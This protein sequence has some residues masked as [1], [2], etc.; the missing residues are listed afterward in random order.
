MLV[1]EPIETHTFDDPESPG[2][3]PD[4]RDPDEGGP[5][6]PSEEEQLKFHIVKVYETMDEEGQITTDAVF[7]RPST[8]GII[9]IEDEKD[10]PAKYE[11]IEWH[12]STQY[13]YPNDWND[14]L[15]VS[16]IINSGKAPTKV[17]I[18]NP[19]NIYEE[20]TLYV[21]LQR[22]ESEDLVPGD[23]MIQQSQISKAIH[24]D[25]KVIGG[26]W[27]N[28]SFVATIGDFTKSHITY[29][30]H[31]CCG[32]CDPS[33]GECHGHT[34]YLEM[35]G[36]SGDNKLTFV[37]D[38]IGAE[39]SLQVKTG[40]HSNTDPKVYTPNGVHPKTIPGMTAAENVNEFVS[41]GNQKN[42][43]ELVTVLWRGGANP[44][45]VPTLALY[46]KADIENRYS[47]DNYEI[48]QA[49]LK[50]A[51]N[52]SKKTRADGPSVYSLSIRF[53][54]DQGASD[55]EG[56]AS[57]VTHNGNQCIYTDT[58]KVYM[59]AG[60]EF[61]YE[62]AAQVG[63]QFYAGAPKGLAAAPFGGPSSSV[64]KK[65]T[66]VHFE[67]NIIQGKQTIKFF[68]YIR[69]T[70]M[71]NSLK[72]AE[73]EEQ[74]KD[75]Y[76][77]ETRY[78]TYV[79]SEWE[80]SILP[81]DAVEVGWSNGNE[82]ESILM[83]SQQ[84]S[85]H[86]KAV[87][88]GQSWNG[89]NQV[90]P[91]GAIYQLSTPN[92]RHTNVKIVTYQTVVDQKTR[93]YL[94]Q[95][96]TGT[97]Y[98]EQQVAKDHTD[99]VNDA[100]E[101]LDNLRIVQWVRKFTESEWA[102]YNS[103]NMPNAW[104]NNWDEIPGSGA[105]CVRGGGQSLSELGLTGKSSTEAKYYMHK[106]GNLISYQSAK[107]GDKTADLIG[108]GETASEGD[109]DIISINQ[110]TTVFKVFTDTAG[111]VYMA[112]VQQ[113]GT[114]NEAIITSLV[115]QLKDVNA[116]T[117]AMGQTG[118]ASIS[119]LADKTVTGAAINGVLSGDAKQ[120]D[121][122]TSFITNIVSSLTRNKGKDKTAAWSTND[123]KWYNEAFDGI[124]SIPNSV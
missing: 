58:R 124:G 66:G 107:L 78:E 88:G 110:V 109:L 73:L 62:F 83:T 24:T 32:G 9:T 120:I 15:S 39:V 51:S 72:L 31:G 17:D 19:N 49:M 118:G 111:N 1:E 100:K 80:S 36:R 98:T 106:A 38:Q 99:F 10:E 115:N 123:G 108:D 48:P 56:T 33:C 116:D 87:N 26:R 40:V 112:S 71:T 3:A 117:V 47:V 28:Y 29:Y 21:R 61:D 43:A 41:D 70:Y 119:V 76:V 69:M 16:P 23:I 84:W 42:G 86:Q 44:T 89:T 92:D 63:V 4:P 30:D 122:R 60:T 22:Q 113:N 35:P 20:R 97:E 93:Q 18:R 74:N 101:V 91:G 82:K 45:D 104:N 50:N 68:P 59:I 96:L 13:K 94:S 37:F 53:G 75:T 81:S 64:I 11:L 52:T 77:Q 121:D 103:T 90:L 14:A 34:C 7:D 57:C 27:G 95:A 8:A 12:Y 102:K 67:N 55:L 54:I 25:D 114:D 2:P 85:L 46:K 5:L 6:T 79:L 105:L 65:S